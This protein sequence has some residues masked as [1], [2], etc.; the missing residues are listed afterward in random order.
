MENV[1]I[2]RKW[3]IA[4]YLVWAWLANPCDLC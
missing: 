3:N 2:G 4:L 1:V